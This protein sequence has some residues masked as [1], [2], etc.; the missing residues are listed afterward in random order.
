MLNLDLVL[1]PEILESEVRDAL[2]QLKSNKSAG[3]DTIFAE[4]LKHL[5]PTGVHI[6]KDLGN[7]L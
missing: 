6:L 3:R 4:E 1:E 5:G 7:Q 2:K